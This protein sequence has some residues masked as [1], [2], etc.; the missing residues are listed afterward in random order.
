MNSAAFGR[1]MRIANCARRRLRCVGAASR[2]T[3]G[4]QAQSLTGM[5][6]RS[7][8]FPTTP[9]TAARTIRRLAAPSRVQSAPPCP[10]AQSAELQTNRATDACR[11]S[12][13]GDCRGNLSNLRPASTFLVRPP[14]ARFRVAVK[15]IQKSRDV[16]AEAAFDKAYEEIL[17]GDPEWKKLG[18]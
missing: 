14:L 5:R 1:S 4:R 11:S 13:F 8:Q 12:R 2:T 18:R 17:G 10:P 7:G 15:E 6:L 9:E 16:S 3:W